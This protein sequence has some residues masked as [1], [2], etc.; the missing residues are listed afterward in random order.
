MV[1]FSGLSFKILLYHIFRS[2]YLRVLPLFN[3]QD[4]W[5]VIRV[6]LLTSI[7]IEASSSSLVTFGRVRACAHDAH[8]VNHHLFRM[9]QI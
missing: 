5:R 3:L 4:T 1:S 6:A 9:S 8:S 7:K 2:N